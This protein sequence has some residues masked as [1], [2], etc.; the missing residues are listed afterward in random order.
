M[1]IGIL[2]QV[3]T[4][5]AELIGELIAAT[6]SSQDTPT[7]E[8]AAQAVNVAISGSKGA[9][10][11]VTT[12]QSGES[13]LLATPP[14]DTEPAWWNRGRKIGAAIVGLSTIIGAIAAVVVLF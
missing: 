2:D 8:Q 10:V 13:S 9:R 14:Q 11:T 7:A 6:P 3:K 5:L 12:Q 4:A 1:I